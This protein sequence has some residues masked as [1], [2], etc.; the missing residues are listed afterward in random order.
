[1]SKTLLRGLELIE[2]IGLHG[3]LTVT[4]LSKRTG[5]DITIVS[6]TV[7]ACEPRGWLTKQDGKITVGPRCAVLGLT[8]PVSQAIQSAEPIVRAIAGVTGTAVTANGLVGHDVMIFASSDGAASD[9]PQGVLS[10]TPVHVLAA[11]R[12]I[13]A[14]LPGEVL[15]ELL[16]P[17]P[18]PDAAQVLASIA[19]STSLSTSLV[20]FG[21]DIS[22]IAPTPT[23]RVELE[24]EL[25]EIRATGFARD[26][27]G[28]HPSLRCIAA[29]WPNTA[30]PATWWC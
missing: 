20:D 9:L 7:S 12:A 23:N 1:M 11:G 27:G 14:H 29:W 28:I 17:E 16:D 13:A 26:H 4:E 10:R 22:R 25:E 5:I 18:F 15:D 19:R 6:R 21:A 8:S 2:A 30:M 24:T 3:P